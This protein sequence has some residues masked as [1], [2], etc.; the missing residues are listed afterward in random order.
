MSRILVGENRSRPPRPPRPP[1]TLLAALALILALLIGSGRHYTREPNAPLDTRATAAA[2]RGARGRVFRRRSAR[3]VCPLRRRRRVRVARLAARGD[4]AHHLRRIL[5]AHRGRGGRLPGGLPRAG[6]QGPGRRTRFGAAGVAAPGRRTDRARVAR[7]RRTAAPL[8]AEP[9]A[10]SQPD[11]A[12]QAETLGILDEEIDRLPERFRRAVVLCYLEGL[13]A[14]EAGQ[15]LGCPTGTVESRLAAARRKLRD[16]LARRGVTL[17][18]GGAGGG[19]GPGDDRA[20]GGGSNDPGRG[21]IC[22]GWGRG[23]RNIG[24]TGQGGSDHVAGAT[25]AAVFLGAAALA[26]ARHRHR[27]GELAGGPA[28]QPGGGHGRGANCPRHPRPRVKQRRGAAD[29]WPLLDECPAARRCSSGSPPTAARSSSAPGAQDVLR[30]RPRR[31]AREDHAD[32]ASAPRTRSTT[33]PSPRTGSTSPPPRVFRGS[34][35]GTRRPA[36]VLEALWPSGK[37]PTQQV[38]FTPDGS[39]ADRPRHPE[40]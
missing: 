17:P 11:R 4:G 1:Y 31:E 33:W 35:C 34:S 13:S 24:P 15:R 27:V 40:T 26:G 28:G 18:V 19:G 20:G 6:P 23:E 22:A 32:S 16:R 8:E 5:R 21:S 3:A 29:A 2:R 38:A 30:P 12:I 10:E 9:P 36:E 7:S 37:L 25:W 39:P 14:V